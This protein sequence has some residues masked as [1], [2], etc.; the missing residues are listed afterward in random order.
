MNL[1]EQLASDL[2]EALISR[3]QVAIDTLRILKS[4]LK[5]AEIAA[6]APLEE[7]AILQV[8]RR[9]V[10]KREEAA[11]T[12]TKI[13]NATLAEKETAEASLLKKYLPAQVP[14]ETVEKYL[15]EAIIA[16]PS[17]NKGDL[18]KQALAHF[19]D[20]TDGRTVSGLV[21]KLLS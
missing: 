11:A 6:G 21:N 5:N 12:Y 7:A 18:I 16:N 17:A 3:D 9:E 13:N 19:G 20:Q 8:I 14:F 4:E 10:K 15:S 2:K 1:N